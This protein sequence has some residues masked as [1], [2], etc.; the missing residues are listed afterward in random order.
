MYTTH[1]RTSASEPASDQLLL[2]SITARAGSL[3]Y[4]KDKA[5]RSLERAHTTH[6][7]QYHRQSRTARSQRFSRPRRR[8]RRRRRRNNPHFSGA[9]AQP[10][11]DWRA[12]LHPRFH[13]RSGRERKR[14]GMRWTDW[15]TGFYFLACLAIENWKDTPAFCSLDSC[16]QQWYWRRRCNAVAY[17]EDVDRFV[18][19]VG[20]HAAASATTATQVQGEAGEKRARGTIQLYTRSR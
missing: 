19:D 16:W 18:D 15:L 13:F 3:A 12:P 11:R 5:R 8:R 6:T 7:A 17:G 20:D 1:S 14:T 4:F 9:Q 2:K 10:L